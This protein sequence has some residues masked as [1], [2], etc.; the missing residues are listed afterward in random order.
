VQRAR[1][2]I[3]KC[4]HPDYKAAMSDYLERALRDAPG[5][6]IRRCRHQRYL[7]GLHAGDSAAP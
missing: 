6:H 4:V 7:D 5:K 3:E 2:I 1:L